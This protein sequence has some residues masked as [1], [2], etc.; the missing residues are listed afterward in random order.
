MFPPAFHIMHFKTVTLQIADRH[1]QVI[2]FPTRK[3]ITGERCIFLGVFREGFVI[4]LGRA[5]DGVVQI[6]AAGAQQ[7]IN[8]GKLGGVIRDT[9]LFEHADGGDFIELPLHFG[10][11]LQLDIN[12]PFQAQSLDLGARQFRLFG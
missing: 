1:T 5:G 10:V 7:A 2:Q 3:N 6:K 11:V 8:R 4:A 12:A 9:H